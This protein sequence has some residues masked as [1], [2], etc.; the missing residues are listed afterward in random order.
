MSELRVVKAL[1]RALSD[2]LDA[3][4]RVILLGEDLARAGGAFNVTRGLQE[5]F[6]ERVLDTPISEPTMTGAALGAAI[7]GLRPVLEIM[8]MDFITLTMDQL[9]NQAAKAHFMFGG[10]VDVPLVLR[11]QHGGG[12]SAGPQHSQCL[13]AWLAHVPGLKVVCPSSVAD[14]YGL[15]RAAIDDP[16]PVVFIENKT[17]Y[18]LKGEFPDDPQ[19]T[20]LGK[21]RV[22]RPGGDVTVVTY[23]AMVYRALEAAEIAATAGIDVEVIDL[24][25]LQPWDKEAALASLARTH[26]AVIAHEAVTAFG[27][28]AEIAATLAH[29]GFDELD[30]PVVRVGAEFMPIPFAPALEKRALPD[31][32]RIG[33]A[34]RTTLGLEE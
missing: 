4:P 19:P 27:I 10:Q 32:E 18:G 14:H 34:I 9:V 21:A 31:A 28:G 25:T 23:G 16:N 17:L 5:R 7:S 24:R 3:D 30:G 22:A 13:E 8:F 6:P 29:E 2:A 15:L 20:P 26:H 12:Q 1:N 11:T 33:A